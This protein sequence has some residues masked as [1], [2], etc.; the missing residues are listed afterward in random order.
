MTRPARVR[1]SPEERSRQLLDLG[2]ELFASTPYEDVHIER[3]AELAGVSR[4]LLYHYFPSKR[5]FFAAMV[6]RQAATMA[7]ETA[8]DPSLPA[9]AQLRA[10]VTAFLD[11]IGRHPHG[12]RAAY[13]GAASGD[14]EVQAVIAESVALHEERI[15]AALTDDHPREAHPLLRV[16]VRSWVVLLRHAGQ[17]WLDDE[18]GSLDLTEVRDLVVDAFLGMLLGLPEAARPPAVA[19]LVAADA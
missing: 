7:E 6:R 16:A 13:R 8:P 17:E 11:H 2:A 14:A 1:L 18:E 19:E 4:G 10:G 9:V 15:L 12:T 3:V 5:A